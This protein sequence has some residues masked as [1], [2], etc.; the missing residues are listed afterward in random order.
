MNTAGVQSAVNAAHMGIRPVRIPTGEEEKAQAS[1]EEKKI[2]FARLLFPAQT[3]LG[4]IGEDS[5]RTPADKVERPKIKCAR[6]FFYIR[7]R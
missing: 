4:P 7:N 2:A 6:G 3:C 1:T 5:G